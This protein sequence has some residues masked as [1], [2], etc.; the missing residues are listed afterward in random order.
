MEVHDCCSITELVT[1]A[2]LHI[3]KQGQGRRDV[4]DGGFDADEA[5]PCHIDGGLKCFGQ[6]IGAS[7]LHMTSEKRL[8]L[9]ARAAE[10][11]RENRSSF[12]LSHNLGGMPNQ[13]VSAVVIAGLIGA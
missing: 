3:F 5:L 8:Q 7:G 4:L 11:Q 1:M 6:P 10:R 12:G 9:L 13:N 2:V